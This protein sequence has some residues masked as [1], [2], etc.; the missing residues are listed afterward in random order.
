MVQKTAITP[1][2]TNGYSAWKKQCCANQNMYIIIMQ[3]RAVKT[4]DKDKSED[5]SK[6]MVY[7]TNNNVHS[8]YNGGKVP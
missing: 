4:I 2:D 1:L 3:F 5:K 8:S 6:C 7:N